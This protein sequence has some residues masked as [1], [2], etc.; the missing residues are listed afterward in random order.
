[1]ASRFFFPVLLALTLAVSACSRGEKTWFVIEHDGTPVGYH[2]VTVHAG[3]AAKAR[4]TRVRQDIVIRST[5][6]G[7][8]FDVRI[9]EDRREDPE[10]GRPRTIEGELRAG[11]MRMH[12]ALVFLDG[13]SV[14]F[15]PEGGPPVTLA[16]GPDVIVP[17]GHT[18]RFL[19]D[20][21][22]AEAA[23]PPVYT[24]LDVAR[25]KFVKQWFHPMGA[26]TLAVA[27]G[28]RFCLSF[29]VETREM[30]IN[31]RIW[32][33][34]ATGDLVRLRSFDGMTTTLDGPE[35]VRRVG[36]WKMDDGIF[37][38]V[39]LLEEDF[40]NIAFMTVRARIRSMGEQLT[41]E[42]LNRPG[43]AFAGTVEDN[44]I[45]GVF[46]LEIPRY[47]GRN[48]PSFP[49]DWT[50]REDLERYLEPEILI[51]ADDPVLVAEAKRITEGSGDA[52]DAAVRL[53][54]WVGTEITDA[55]PG[56]SARQT[57]DARRGECAAHARLLT[58]L[59]RGA[60]IPARLATGCMYTPIQGGSFGQHVWN[61]VYMG[62]AGWIPVDSAVE[63]PDHIDSGH[64]RLGEMVSFR[65]E[66]M[67]VLDYR[68]GSGDGDMLTAEPSSGAP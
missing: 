64:I 13:D 10:T 15:T 18:Y 67:E 14:R 26:E 11:D 21:G 8:D 53:A 40:R 27:A 49:P 58:A 43:Q 24:L 38:R 42:S 35:C 54:R 2:V 12:S 5:L 6:L 17:D 32:I 28:P 20:D 51:E 62:D 30:G 9:R 45:D 61:E 23:E 55:V 39:D 52:W 60:G 37:A 44:V 63:E 1:M 29:R 59:C 3:D 16:C 47:D 48:A 46:T 34:A 4:D 31:Q 22:A 33:D 65:P 25:G 7:G 56:A 57:Y 36:R 68:L 41:A 66:T 50:D 19:I